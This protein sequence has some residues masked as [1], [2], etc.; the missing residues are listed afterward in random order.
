VF[1]DTHIDTFDDEP[2]GHWTFWAP[3]EVIEPDG[4]NPGAFL[5]AWGMDAL[6]PWVTTTPGMG[7]LFTG[8]FRERQVTSLGVDA[9]LIY[10]DYPNVGDRPMTLLLH[11]DN[12]TP[13]DMQD[14]WAAYKKGPNIPFL[15]EGW[16]SYDYEIPYDSPTF[17]PDWGFYRFGPNSP[18]E[19]DWSVLMA[20]VSLASFMWRDPELYYIFQMWGAG[21]DNAR[22]S[23]VP[24]PASLTLL[25]LGVLAA[26]RRRR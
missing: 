3:H 24:E 6:S 12:G 9:D 19:P 26:L 23:W 25:G 17:P 1:A 14:D 22:I 8:D 21:I 16:L 13:G 15:H 7:G 11:C 4:G 18:D 5:H 10:V 2:E 20:D